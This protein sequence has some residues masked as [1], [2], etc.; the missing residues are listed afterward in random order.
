MR[1]KKITRSLVTRLIL[2]GTLFAIVATGVGYYQVTGILRESLT[3]V[4]SVQQMALAEHVARDVDE[5]LIEQRTFLE[6]MA[7]ALPQERL[8][9]SA[10][11]RD[12]LSERQA[13]QSFFSMGLVVADAKGTILASTTSHLGGVGAS[14][15]AVAVFQT[16]R[17]GRSLIGQLVVGDATSPAN[18]PMAAP[19]RDSAGQVVAVLLG[20]TDLS[21]HGFLQRLMEGRNQSGGGL[22]LISPQD[23]LFVGSTDPT[24]LFKPTPPAGVNHLH[25]RAMDG[26]RG[27]GLT[28]YAKG[29]E[30][31][32]AMASVP[33]TGWF[34]VARL[35]A[36]QGLVVVSQVQSFLIQRGALI[37]LITIVIF[38]SMMAWLLRPLFRS[39]ALADHMTLGATPLAPLPVVRDDEIGL[40]T[41][42]FNRLLAK[43]VNQ[44]VELERLAHHDELTGLPN[45][46]LLIDRIQQAL[47][48]ARRQGTQVAVLFMDLNGFKL[49]N[50][51][52]GHD[53]GDEVLREI[54]RR[55]LTTVRQ[56]DTLA[57]LGGDEFVLL[58]PDLAEGASAGVFVLAQKCIDA[59][60]QPLYV[61][62]S[63]QRFSVSVGIAVQGGDGTPESLLAAADKAMYEA[64]HKGPGHY[65]IA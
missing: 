43:L 45:R 32:S 17:E 30:E 12:W 21:A 36:T 37:R 55:L 11:L 15:A 59:V 5:K 28:T 47:A 18:L 14:V 2:V 64:K 53:A 44:Q 58:M 3:Q 46:K 8:L 42:A 13:L 51:T 33:S 6:R 56:A 62:G 9:Q 19:I 52:L 27:S 57:R 65:S 25:D 16:A 24:L 48:R 63:E 34:V 1:I 60:A 29:L 39:A 22:L 38:G 41:A 4:V 31:I 35:P 40:L 26:F 54:S 10:Y 49:V 50:D 7:A 23:K 20:S 61:R